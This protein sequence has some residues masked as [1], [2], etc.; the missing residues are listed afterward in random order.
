MDS[1][2]EQV[3]EIQLDSKK[4]L[5]IYYKFSAQKLAKLMNT[6]HYEELKAVGYEKNQTLLSPFVVRKFLELRGIPVNSHDIDKLR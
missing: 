4:S 1:D 5:R 3:N 6:V 2:N